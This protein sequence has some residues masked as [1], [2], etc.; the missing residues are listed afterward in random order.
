LLHRNKTVLTGR[1][2]NLRVAVKGA[3]MS[4]K[5]ESKDTSPKSEPASASASAAPHTPFNPFSTAAWDPS[6][7][8]TSSQQA[9]QKMMNEAFGRA[10]SFAD[11]YASIEQQMYKRA[12]EA[13]DTWAQIA[14]DTI[15]YS[16]QLTAQA[17]KVS[18]DAI[19]KTG[20]VGA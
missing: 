11:E 1:V 16:Q 14:R 13:V 10:Q 18:L 3:D 5:P 9:W 2:A 8:F 15:S 17:R 20:V 19:R 6:A 7:A 12:L 4:Q